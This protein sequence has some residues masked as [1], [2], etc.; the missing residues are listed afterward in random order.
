[1]RSQ[2]IALSWMIRRAA[3]GRQTTGRGRRTIS[4]TRSKG[5][6]SG[7]AE[8]HGWTRQWRLTGRR[9]RSGREIECRATGRRLGNALVTLGERESGTARLEEA[10]TAYLAALEE[11]TRDRAPLNWAAAQMNLGSGLWRLGERESGTARLEEAIAAYQA[12]LAELTGD[13]LPA[14]LGDGPD[15]P[16]RHAREAREAGERHGA[17]GA[18]GGGVPRGPRGVGARSEAS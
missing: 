12:A 3:L 2:S 8:R 16:R 13:R 11:L 1:M 10:V 6:A 9:S 17:S 5:S 4:A 7:R 15:Q 18:C 14:R